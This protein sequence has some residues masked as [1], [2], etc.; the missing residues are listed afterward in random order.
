MTETTPTRASKFKKKYS[1]VR[2]VN[3]KSSSNYFCCENHFDL[4]EDM[5][6]YLYYKMMGGPAKVKKT[7]VPHK[8]ECQPDRK[9]RTTKIARIG[10]EKR[11]R[12]HLINEI[13]EQEVHHSSSENV[14]DVIQSTTV[15]ETLEQPTVENLA[16]NV[17]ESVSSPNKKEDTTVMVHTETPV[18]QSSVAVQ[19]N[20]RSKY[21]NVHFTCNIKKSIADKCSSLIK[22][23]ATINAATSP[24][25]PVSRK[26]SLA[27]PSLSIST[28]ISSTYTSSSNDFYV[29]TDEPHSS[30]TK[31]E[32]LVRGETE[33]LNVTNYFISI[34][35]KAYLG[36]PTEWSSLIDLLSAKTCISA[37]N[38]NLCLMKI[39]KQDTFERLGEQFC[40]TPSNASITF[41][42]AI[43]ILSHVLKTLVFFPDQNVVKKMLPIAFRNSY[44]HVQSIVDALEIQLEKPS[45]PV[46][47]ALTWSEYK[48]CNTLKYLIS[49]TLD[50]FINFISTGYG[51]RISDVLLFEK[52]GILDK[53][54]DNC[55]VMADRGF[56]NI[57][58]PLTTKKCELIKPPS[59]SSTV[60][61]TN[62]DVLETKRIASLRI[63]VEHVIGRLREFDFL[64]PHA[65]IKHS[66]ISYTDD[67]IVIVSSLLN[68]QTPIIRK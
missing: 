26:K 8:F 12:R 16:I 23:P 43:P 67:I 4:A 15:D 60:K 51:G 1:T 45:D 54:P 7:A 63:H 29:P 19:V 52:C 68:L 39:R 36:I 65:V 44:N 25:K 20:I 24:M 57:Q 35:P 28:N 37:D 38:I 34:N 17:I 27:L 22:Y 66:M 13:L 49:Y 58:P 2:R 46:N 41:S 48:K 55:A 42:K 33:I 32:R 59:V 64:K 56:K 31:N 11:Q 53:L 18:K 50:G 47:Q 61:P 9:C 5:E 3:P 40:M 14:L 62:S 10:S 21:R 6:N 30:P